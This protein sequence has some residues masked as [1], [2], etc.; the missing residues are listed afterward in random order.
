MIFD[1]QQGSNFAGHYTI[2][3]WSCGYKL[4][5]KCR[6]GCATGQLYRDTPYGILVTS[7]NPGSK[8]H[9]YAGLSFRLDSSLLIVEGCF[10]VDERDSE[11]QA[12]GLQSELL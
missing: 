9:H 10:D 7:G 3:Q 12:P 11:G 2:A 5:L 6:R 1:A 4:Q 8:D